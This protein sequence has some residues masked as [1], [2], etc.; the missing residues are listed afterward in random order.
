MRKI[1]STL[2]IFLT[3]GTICA[4]TVTLTFTAKDAANH[5]VQLNRV[6]ITNL[7]KNWQETIYWPDTV[8][9]MNNGTGTHDQEMP[10]DFK[11][12]QNTPNPFSGLT[13]VQVKTIEAGRLHIEIT[14]VGGRA[15]LSKDISNVQAGTYT[16]R[17]CLSSPQTYMLTARQ[18]DKSAS[19]KMINNGGGGA[20]SIEIINFNGTKGDNLKPKGSVNRPW[21]YGDDLVIKGYAIINNTECESGQIS[22]QLL[23]E[24][25]I[26]LN[27]SEVSHGQPCPGTNTMTDIDGNTYN[28]VQIGQQCWMKE[29]LRTT[30]Y[31]DGTAIALGSDTSTSV[32]Y[33]YY[34]GNSASNVSTYGYLYN[35]KAVMGEAIHS[36][37]N[38]SGIQ[39]VC[40]DGWHLPSEAEFL[41]LKHYVSCQS[42]YWCDYDSTAIAKSLASAEGWTPSH[43]YFCA[44]GNQ[45]DNNNATGFS[46]YPAGC[47]SS[48]YLIVS[49]FG[50][51]TVFWSTTKNDQNHVTS[52]DL[53]NYSWMAGVVEAG[54]FSWGGSVRCIKGGDYLP[55]VR[56]MQ[57]SAITQT[58]A[59]CIGNVLDGGSSAV[60][61]RGMCWSTSP[62]PTVNDSHTT[63]GSGTSVFTSAVSGLERGHRYYI[64]AY[65]TNS[66]GTAYGEELVF[67]TQYI[68]QACSEAPTVTDIDGNVYNTVKIGNQCWMKENLRTTRYADGVSIPLENTYA[69]QSTAYRYYPGLNASNLNTY[70]YMYNWKAVMRNHSSSS[71]NPSGVQGVCPNGWHLPSWTEWMQLTDFVS[72]MYAFLCNGDSAYIAKSLAATTGWTVWGGTWQSDYCAPG[73]V[74]QPNNSTG[75]SA[76][77]AGEI[78]YRVFNSGGPGSSAVL[79]TLVTNMSSY[80]EINQQASFW[81]CTVRPTYSYQAYCFRIKYDEAIIDSWPWSDKARGQSV[82]CVKN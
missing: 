5:Y 78:P 6:I 3:L 17:V 16:F 37:N 13:D 14:D 30:R 12:S 44:V 40:P 43:E 48:Y 42:Q 1:V 69:S 61:A 71:A 34:P 10:N 47:F 36:S 56:T 73:F 51:Y 24:E 79:D 50:E 18:G 80:Y 54:G 53:L 23:Y 20:N 72:G 62:N 82:R 74:G 81:S 27:F 65:A 45:Q 77:P 57:V 63:D 39:G 46:A 35:W 58:S 8:L 66:S 76:L 4:Q 9:T 19:I 26:A 25:T 7:T 22:H 59:S 67:V 32:A 41:Q 38:P 15:V 49:G 28:T 29:N 75:F 60:T 11:L 55:V 31:A 21:S 68:P 70:G 33:R 52:L 64:R 2:I